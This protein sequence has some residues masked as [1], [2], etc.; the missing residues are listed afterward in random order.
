MPTMPSK[1]TYLR[2]PRGPARWH[3]RLP[4]WLFRLHLGWLLAGHFLQ[5]THTGRVSG[6]PRRTILEVLRHDR[7]T[8][9]YA[10]MAG[11]GPASDWV[12]NIA[13]NPRVAIAV[14]LRRFAAIA[15]ILNPDDAAADILDYTHRVPVARPIIARVMGYTWDG[16]EA[17]FRALAHRAT[18]VAFRPITSVTSAASAAQ[19]STGM[20]SNPAPSREAVVS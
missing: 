5:L 17:D 12:R 3:L 13:Q 14:G 8:D 15:T 9:T 7:A 6:L 16:S 19:T 1:V 11:F 18:V 20:P 2:P 10:V 4:N